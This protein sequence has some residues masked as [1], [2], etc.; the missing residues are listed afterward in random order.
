MKNTLWF[1]G[2]AAIGA[3]SSYVIC[4]RYYNKKYDEHI[5]MMEDYYKVKDEYVRTESQDEEIPRENG[6]MTSEERQVIK[7]KLREEGLENVPYHQMYRQKNGYTEQKL[8]EGEHPEEDDE[9]DDEDIVTPEEDAF[10][11]H[12][13][14]RNR[15]PKIISYDAVLELPSYYDH[16]TL[17]F[18]AYTEELCDENGEPIE[19]P[20]LLVGN[21][22][23]K[24]G[25]VD[26]DEELIFVLN[27][28]LDTV[29][30]IQKKFQCCDI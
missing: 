7:E 10:D 4:G 19:D 5:K 13:R 30:E 26:N 1:L 29:Y 27:Y 9:S 28:A 15:P 16:E 23:E 22:L 12:M 2:G 21:C 18:M 3:L 17:L 8:A 24:F 14:N 20:G 6:V 11:D 25:F